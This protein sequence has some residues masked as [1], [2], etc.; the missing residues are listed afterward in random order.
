MRLTLT[1]LALM[2]AATIA[3]IG[4]R[5]LPLHLPYFAWKYGGSMLWAVALYWLVAALMPRARVATIFVVA[6][7][8]AAAVEFSRLIHTPGFDHF[9]TTLAGKLL[10][11]RYFSLWNIAA[12]WLAIGLIALA[13]RHSRFSA[14]SECETARG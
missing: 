3:G 1:S 5:F 12:Y 2:L 6:L 14:Q 4:W 10:L 13:D 9:R 7:P 8:A 11:G